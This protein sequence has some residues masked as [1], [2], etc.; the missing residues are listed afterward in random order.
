MPFDELRPKPATRITSAWGNALVDA[1]NFL[2]NYV[3]SGEQDI[4]VRKVTAKAGE[5]SESLT[6]QGKTVLKDGDP[7]YIAD[8]YDAAVG[9]VTAAV[10]A[11]RATSLLEEVRDHTSNLPSIYAWLT[12]VRRL[13]TGDIG[14]A[15]YADNVGLARESTLSAVSSNVA[16]I[17][18]KLDSIAVDEAGRVAAAINADNVGLAREST[19]ATVS[20]KLDNLATE[21]TLSAVSGKLDKLDEIGKLVLFSYTTTPLAANASWTS[22]V[23]DSPY[24]RFIC[25]SVYA[26]QPGTLYVEQSPDG[27]NWDVVDSFSV[28]AGTG[29]KFSVEKV[30]PYVRVRYVNGANSQEVF[31][32][33]VYRRLRL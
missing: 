11:A 1:L 8:L 24:T 23:D 4:N 3:T 17:K 29:L 10:D 26:D 18:S 16:S 14:V 32:L 20:S 9:K 22:S 21:S 19:L 15:V 28:P 13:D 33:Y 31:R 25:G 27:S 30:L 6:L 12:G 2:Y 5:F 7:I